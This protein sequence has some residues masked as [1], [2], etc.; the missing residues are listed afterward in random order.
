ML[1]QSFSRIKKALTILLAVFFVATLTVGAV[2]ACT[3]NGNS[4]MNGYNHISNSCSSAT[5]HSL[6][7]TTPCDSC[8]DGSCDSCE[9][10][11]CDDNCKDNSGNSCK[12]GSGNSCGNN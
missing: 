7:S 3:S 5:D 12:E 6:S 10:G 4:H 8:K 9:D 11:S 2:S 1:K